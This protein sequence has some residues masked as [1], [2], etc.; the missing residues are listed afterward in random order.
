MAVHISLFQKIGYNPVYAQ[1]TAFLYRPALYPGQAPQSFYILLCCNVK[2]LAAVSNCPYECSC[3]FLQNYLTDTTLSVVADTDALLREVDEKTS[4]QPGR[5][6]RA[7]TWELGDSLALEAL[8]GTAAELVCAFAKRPNLLL[9]LKTKSAQVSGLL[10]LP[11]NGRTVVSW[12][13]N[14]E[15]AVSASTRK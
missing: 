12:T 2:V 11:H 9:E 6:F 7:G 3:C 1:I 13:V 4:K 5:L 15:S 14:P 8:T 10:D